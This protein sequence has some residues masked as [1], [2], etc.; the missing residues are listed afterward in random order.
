MARPATSHCSQDLRRT[1]NLCLNCIGGWFV[2][3]YTKRFLRNGSLQWCV[4]T[5]CYEPKSLLVNFNS[6]L[7][8]ELMG[9]GSSPS[10]SCEKTASLWENPC[11][12][13]RDVFWQ[14]ENA[15]MLASWWWKACRC[16][17]GCKY[18]LTGSLAERLGLRSKGSRKPHRRF[19]FVCWKIAF[20][21]GMFDMFLLMLCNIFGLLLLG[22]YG[23]YLL[24][25]LHWPDSLAFHIGSRW[26]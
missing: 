17:T 25:C 16:K 1:L 6:S 7:E 5:Q 20:F 12:L 26:Q 23:M 22:W 21:G 15:S 2:F 18:S 9:F 10:W 14:V 19:L 13:G 8:G 24:L 3:L 11:V 4:E